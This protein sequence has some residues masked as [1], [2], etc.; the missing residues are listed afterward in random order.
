[1]KTWWF[2][3]KSVAHILTG[4]IEV[5]LIGRNKSERKMA[6]S[7]LHP[8]PEQL[9]SEYDAW[10]VQAPMVRYSKLPFR[11]LCA[12]YNTHITYTPM[13][14]STEFSRSEYARA[15]DFSTSPSER[16][17]FN[18]RRRR[19]GGVDEDAFE[20][21]TQSVRGS[22]IAQFAASEPVSFM[23]SAE[24]IANHVDAI[25]LNTGC[26]TSWAYTEGIGGA[27]LRKP[28]VV[29]DIIRTTY[30]RVG[31]TLPVTLKIRIDKEEK[32]TEQLIKNAVMAGVSLIGIHGR[33]R[34]QASTT[35]VNLVG[36]RLAQSFASVPTISNG[37]AWSLEESRRIREA[38]GC[39]GVMS[40]RGIL[41]NPGMFA[42]Y[43]ETPMDCVDVGVM[44]SD[45]FT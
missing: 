12:A 29:R 18:L 20:K 37:D 3:K 4:Y 34:T 1:M 33:Y 13:M 17:L 11:E 36:V 43:E 30:D 27:L 16:G 39:E 44:V 15:S 31:S 21:H 32:R 19:R 9:L 42:G 25:D 8:T 26:P 41:S 22:L 2:E 38:T 35:P 10:T 28:E 5:Q 24:L 14:L 23:Q 6:A 40:A 7:T 45:V